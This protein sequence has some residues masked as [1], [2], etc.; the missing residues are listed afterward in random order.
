MHA[1]PSS[2]VLSPL[3]SDK[4]IEGY[5]IY[6]QVAGKIAIRKYMHTDTSYDLSYL[7]DEF[8]C[9]CLDVASL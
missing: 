1:V 8:V 6:T 7:A 3:S 5:L 2:I 9:S 4:H